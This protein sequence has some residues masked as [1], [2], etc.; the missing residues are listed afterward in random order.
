MPS[1]EIGALAG[2]VG[3]GGMTAVEL[4]ARSR[5]GLTVLLDWQQNQATVAKLAKAPPESAVLPGL[6]LHFV[7][8]LVAGAI[9]ALLLPFVPSPLPV[10]GVGLGYGAVLFAL[11]LVAHK[12]IT[13]RAPGYESKG[14]TAIAVGLLAHLV[15]GGLLAIFVAA[16]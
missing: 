3:A 11:T 12:P 5:W 6:A 1:W 13:G 14:A 16:L 4:V 10:A 15:Y 9:F 2:L 8:G 7:H